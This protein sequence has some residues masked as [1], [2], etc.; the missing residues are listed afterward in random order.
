MRVGSSTVERTMMMTM[1]GKSFFFFFFL[2]L[3]SKWQCI[4]FVLSNILWMISGS[5]PPAHSLP[6]GAVRAGTVILSTPP[7][8]TELYR[9]SSSSL[10]YPC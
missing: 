7:F 6:I 1:V 3:K 4:H 9:L 8:R 10:A 5:E 2:L